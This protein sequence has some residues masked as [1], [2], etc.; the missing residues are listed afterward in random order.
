VVTAL[1]THA[2]EVSDMAARGM[3][4]VHEMMMQGG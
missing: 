1:Q 3:Q 4:A 2:A